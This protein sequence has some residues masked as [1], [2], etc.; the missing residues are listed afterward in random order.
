MDNKRN[1]NPSMHNFTV[2][3]QNGSY[4]FRLHKVAISNCI[5]QKHKKEIT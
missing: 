5:Y 1:Y 4:T 3:F 2:A